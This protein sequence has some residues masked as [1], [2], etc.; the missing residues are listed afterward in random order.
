LKS[1]KT[2]AGDSGKP[3]VF[4]KWSVLVLTGIELLFLPVAA[5]LWI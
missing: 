4:G 2:C 5:V 3:K 1:A